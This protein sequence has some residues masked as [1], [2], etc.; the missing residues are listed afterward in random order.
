MLAGVGVLLTGCAGEPA[1][2]PTVTVTAEAAPATP[3]AT[4]DASAEPDGPLALGSAAEF[5]DFSMIVHAVNLD[6]VPAPAPQPERAEDKWASADVEY[7][8]KI[9]SSITSYWWRMSA[10]DNRQYE[11]SDVG[12]SAFQEPAYAW[13]EVPVAADSCHRGWITFTVNREAVLETV[14]YANDKGHSAEW[15]IPQ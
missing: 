9:E 6:P 7:C 5:D 8:S 11:P 13:G 1:P 14:R 10:A 2:A 12:Y 3:V 4:P 15:A